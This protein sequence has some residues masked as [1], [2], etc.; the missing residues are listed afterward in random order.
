[1]K[2]LLVPLLFLAAIPCFSQKAS[3]RGTV[4]DTSSKENLFN[5]TI[6]V[7]RSKD[8][9]LTRFTR[10]NAQ[11]KF[12]IN[13]LPAGNYIL[14]VSY[15]KYADF[16]E[17]VTLT[18]TSVL[19]FE[20][21]A[22]TLKAKLLE[23][24]VVK[25]KIA[26][27]KIKGDTTEFTADSFHV[28]ANASVEQLL[29]K[30][31]GIQVDKNGKITAQG[32]TVQKVLVDG[33]EFFGDDPTLVTQNLRADMVDKVQLFDKKSDQSVFTGVDDGQ[34][35]KTINLKLKDSKKNGY[36]GKV[37]A[38]IGTEG[39]YDNQAMINFFKRKQK[40]SAYGILSNTGKTGLNWQDRDK[41]GQ[42]F[43]SGADYDE[44]TGNYFISGGNDDLDNWD[45]RYNG[46]GYP[47]VAS[48]GLHYNNKWN[49]DKQTINANYK[50]LDLD[51]T[52][53]SAVNSQ[54][55]LPDTFYFN[56]QAEKFSNQILRNRGNATY[57]IQIDSS[58]SIKIG[59]DAG[60]DHKVTNSNFISEALAEDNSKVN[61]SA[62]NINTIGDLTTI[63]SNLLWRKK[64]RK[65][66]RTVSINFR[67]N[68]QANN[69]DGYLYSKNDYYYGGILSTEQITDQYK[70]NKSEN[71]V[72][73]SRITYSE[74]LS[75]FSSLIVN[76]GIALN[77]SFSEKSSYNKSNNG[78]Y[79]ELD[80]IYSNDYHFNI[81]THRTGLTYNLIKKKIR[82]NAGTNIGFTSF[83]QKDVNADT[84]STRDFINWYPQASF[85]YSFT[86]QKRLSFRYNGN[87][88]QPT[89]QQIQPI[90][91]N[92]DP[93]NVAVGNPGLKPSFT[94][95]FS[96]NFND[97]KVLSERNIYMGL[98]YRFTQNAI[99]N[100]DHIDTSGKRTYQSVNVDGNKNFNGYMGYGF[101]W[102]KPNIEMYFSG[103]FNFGN[104]VNIINNVLN[105]TESGNYSLFIDVAKRKDK[106]YDI[107]L[108]G[109]ATYTNSTSSVQN[110]ITTQYWTFV[111]RP[112]FDIYFPLKFQL[113]ADCEMNFRQK[114]STFDKNTNVALLNAWVG[115]KMLKGDVL[116]V[117]VSGNDILN[118]NLGFSRTVNS[119]YVSQNTYT[120]IQR[121][122]MLSLVW[123]F[124][125][126]GSVAP[127]QQ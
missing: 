41:Y 116:L 101:K 34:K 86:S 89:I 27:I 21:L 106:K 57:E 64:L 115:K 6:S 11:G 54:Y 51:V 66:G 49:E 91:T 53:T 92:D 118:Q 126:Q 80:S 85:T 31:P 113:H 29:K 38:G 26:A 121:F 18:D 13:T 125:K 76:Y 60:A 12:Q 33:E 82:F 48:G 58:S 123:N 59:V 30:L 97:Y 62:R 44:A 65:K 114:T 46:K 63:N 68:Y 69:S 19:L 52:G 39:Y 77:N 50:I 103:N 45:G 88:T 14:L 3:I 5:A 23:E 104:Y 55:I 9:I 98:N 67:E 122:F 117:K 43:A 24:V 100:R 124:T 84:T 94:N 96:V 73:D 1:M 15:P 90:V 109:G 37:N 79:T 119:N 102:K 112:D 110:N 75:T 74:P 70:N 105:T 40:F 72:L 61:Q 120:T 22:L 83:D 8:S 7:L 71:I 56:N 42:S 32:E 95:A 78:K 87:T 81:F 16:V 36:F 20:K 111:V 10:S 93:L 47:S 28:E 99:T 108:R 2:L 4:T 25:Q 17:Q 35:E 127:P 107:G